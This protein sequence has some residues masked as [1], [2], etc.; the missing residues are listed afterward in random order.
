LGFE[1]FLEFEDFFP[2]DVVFEGVFCKDPGAAER[3][4]RF[5][6]SLDKDV[7][8]FDGWRELYSAAEEVEGDVLVYDAGPV[9]LHSRNIMESLE[10][11][12]HH[13]AERPPS[14]SREKHLSERKLASNTSV[15]F[16]VDFIERESPVVKKAERVLEEEDIEKIEVFRE[17]SFG[18][19]KVL[20]RVDFAHI[21]GG[22]VLDKLSNDIYIL[23]FLGNQLE[24]EDAEID[25]LMPEKLRSDKVLQTDGS[26]SEEI[27]YDTAIG[28]CKGVFSSGD[29][30][31]EMYSS[32]LGVGEKAREWSQEIDDAFGEEILEMRHAEVSGKGFRS[33]EARFFTVKGSRNLLGDLINRRLYDLD[34][35]EKLDLPEFPRD[36]LYR[37]LERAVLDAAGIDVKAVEEEEI[38]VF[39]N[40]LF[41]LQEA[42]KDFELDDAV[43][44]ATKRIRSLMLPDKKFQDESRVEGI[45]R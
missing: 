17:S 5:A 6:D 35:G 44:N 40:S 38:D 9:Q 31:V 23:D 8:F 39:M 18:V 37:V 20:D 25:L 10:R 27:G 29:A 28:K 32:W 24:F 22:C 12:F 4:E 30:E 16:K 1:K 21:R 2:V 34:S 7:E 43:E 36:Q 13:L 26:A 42:E 33:Q 19:Q 14:V 15:T 41:D 3:A 11:G 45:A